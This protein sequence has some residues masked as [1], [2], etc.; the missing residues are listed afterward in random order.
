MNKKSSGELRSPAMQQ[1]RI[2]ENNLTNREEEQLQL[3]SIIPTPRRMLL[4]IEREL[5][6]KPV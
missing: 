1:N 6:S 2:P 4:I 3:S 5:L